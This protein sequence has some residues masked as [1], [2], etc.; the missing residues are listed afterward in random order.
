MHLRRVHV[1]ME[2]KM[3]RLSGQARKTHEKQWEVLKFILVFYH[4]PHP[5]KVRRS[6]IQSLSTIEG[7]SL[8]RAKVSFWKIEEK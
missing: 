2:S 1:H 6:E 8:G 4:A 7:H 3:S 5:W